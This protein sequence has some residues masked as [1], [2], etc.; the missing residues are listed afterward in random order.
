MSSFLQDIAMAS[1]MLP[2]LL[3]KE[4]KGEGRQK[5]FNMRWIDVG[6]SRSRSIDCL[7]ERAACMEVPKRYK[8]PSELAQERGKYVR[9]A[10]DFVLTAGKSTGF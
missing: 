5:C 7:R 1:E 9:S 8:S 10:Q 6:A 4:G 2:G 3:G